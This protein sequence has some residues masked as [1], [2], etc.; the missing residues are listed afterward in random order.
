MP[1]DNGTA[2]FV[3][4]HRRAFL[5]MVYVL[6]YS[7]MSVRMRHTK[8]HTHNRRSHHALSSIQTVVDAKSNARRLPHRLDET[9]GEYRG[10]LIK[11]PRVKKERTKAEK[12]SHPGSKQTAQIEEKSPKLKKQSAHDGGTDITRTRRSV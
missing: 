9:T 5:F 1:K 11:A 7:H 12:Y 4:R 10:T 6:G 2:H 3:A 8:S